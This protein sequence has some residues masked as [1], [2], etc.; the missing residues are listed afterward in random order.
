MFFIA[1]R[2]N[3]EGPNPKWENRPDYIQEALDAGY[4]V[5]VDIWR[6][7]YGPICLGHDGPDI[8]VGK[9]DLKNEKLWLHCKNIYALRTVQYWSACGLNYFF[10]EN[11]PCVLTSTGYIWTFPGQELTDNS[12]CVMPE[13][14]DRDKIEYRLPV[15]AGICSDYIGR[16]KEEIL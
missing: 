10:H 8:D 14:Q 15:V 12:I 2:G 6:T 5:E 13:I 3:I 7:G 1:H 9:L 11:D 16:Y 4:E